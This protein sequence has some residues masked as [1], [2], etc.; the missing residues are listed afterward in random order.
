MELGSSALV[1][2]AYRCRGMEIES[3]GGARCRRVGVGNRALEARY[4]CVDV[5]FAS[6]VLELW[7]YPAGVQT[8][9]YGARELGSRAAGVQTWRYGARKLRR[10]AAGVQT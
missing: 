7:R 4:T 10:R 8:R 3:L 6:S 9:R 5:E 2:R 1:L